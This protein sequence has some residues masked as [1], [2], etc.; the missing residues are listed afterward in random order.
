MRDLNALFADLPT[1]AREAAASAIP[2]APTAKLLADLA[3]PRASANDPD[4]LIKHRFLCR[5]GTALLVG[6]TG[7]GKSSLAMQLAMSFAIGQPCLGIPPARPLRSLIIQAE[8]DEGDMAEMRDGVAAGLK[9]QLDKAGHESEQAV[10]AALRG[11][12]VATVDDKT[13]PAFAAVLEG[14]CEEYRPD[15]VFVDPAFA[16]IGGDASAQKEVS[17]FLRN[18]VLPVVHAAQIGLWIVHHTNKPPTGQQKPGYLPGDYAYLGAGSAEWA[19]VCR[20]V[21]AL[22]GTDDPKV[23]EFR[24]AKRGFRLR[25]TEGDVEGAP[26]TT[27]RHIAY[28]RQ[29]GVICWHPASADQ[30]PV[31]KPDTRQLIVDAIAG[32]ARTVTDIHKATKKAKST[33]SEALNRMLQDQSPAVRQAADGTLRL[34]GKATPRA[35]VETTGEDDF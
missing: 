7:A 15:M 16:Y 6:P 28:D 20:G 2:Q 25:W 4:E 33:I 23:F 10:Q 9:A 5:G 11:V 14:L 26:A 30:I 12:H 24:A 31:S 17:P 35:L 21:L 32:G 1:E 34:T 19:N 22:R 3:N 18:H 8:N 13:G 29:T 27:V